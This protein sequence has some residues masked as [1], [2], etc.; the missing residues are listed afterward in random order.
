VAVV[1]LRQ[2]RLICAGGT[3]GLWSTSH[4]IGCAAERGATRRSTTSSTTGRKPR[5]RPGL[6]AH[7][8]KSKQL[9]MLSKCNHSFLICV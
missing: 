9:I 5:R 3:N 6:P 4:V 8:K 1:A 2:L 7:F